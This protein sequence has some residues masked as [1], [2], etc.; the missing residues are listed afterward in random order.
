MKLLFTFLSILW[1]LAPATQAAV[2]VTQHPKSI[3]LQNSRLYISLATS[4]GFIT[5]VTL[6]GVDML[7]KAAPGFVSAGPYMDYVGNT[8]QT[9]LVPGRYAKYSIFQGKDSTGVSYGG[10][11]LSQTMTREDAG[12]EGQLLE[13]YWFL[14]DGETGLHM[15]TRLAYNNKERPFLAHLS[16]LRTLFRPQS[17]MWTHLSSSN[18]FYVPAPVPNPANPGPAGLGGAVQV[19]DTTWDLV[20]PND[21]YVQQVSR[22]WTKYTMSESYRHQDV[23]GLFADGSK[24]AN[25]DT[26][27]VWTIMNTKDTYFGATTYSDLT[28][29]GILYNVIVSNHHGNQSPNITDG[30]DRTFGPSICYFNRGPKG[31]KLQNLR[32]D[33]AQYANASYATAFYDSIATHVPGYMPSSARG[34][35]QAQVALPSGAN[36]PVAILSAN[37][38]DYQDNAQ[39]PHAYQYW[40]EIPNGAVAISGV[41]PGTYRLTIYADGIFGDYTQDGIVITAGKSTTQRITW[42]PESN[43]VEL[44]RIGTPDKTSGEFK[45]GNELDLS[46]FLHPPAYR[47][48]WAQK[49]SD[50]IDNFPNGVNYTV[51]KDNV[52]TAMNVAHWSTYGGN[53]VRPHVVIGTGNINNWTVNFDV[54]ACSLSKAKTATLTIQ[55]AGAETAVGNNHQEKQTSLLSNIPYNVEVNGNSLPTWIIQWY[56]SGSCIIRSSIQCY[57]NRNKWT[58]PASYLKAGALNKIVLMM[59]YGG[60]HHSCKAQRPSNIYVQY[61]ALRLEVN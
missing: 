60:K 52:S 1:V 23:H 30:L 25:G 35:F 50:F 44:W 24:T 5:T 43:G 54:S 37:G 2:T 27:G 3:I 7:G 51:G 59:P 55:L 14:R 45:A 16:A 28:V 36:N 12:A 4:T 6:D 48:Y 58:F 40:E 29:D 15:F 21:P 56:T 26:F 13:Q 41:R 33:A 18:E 17:S 31:E 61:D 32:Q 42:H 38:L 39:D 49:S 57:Q 9:N 34:S 46:H 47:I 10:M 11:V 22:Y 20:R 53:A 19:Q 8:Q